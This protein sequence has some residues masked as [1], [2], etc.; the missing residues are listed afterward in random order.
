MQ[1]DEVYVKSCFDYKNGNIIGSAANNPICS[2]KTVMAY[3]VSSAFGNSKEIVSLVP[4][5]NINCNE[6]AHFTKEVCKLLVEC[7]FRVIVIITDNNRINRALFD[8]LS[9]GNGNNL[10]HMSDDFKT[11]LTFDSVHLLKSI[12]NN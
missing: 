4:V 6:F 12:R 3:L 8:I 10:Y 9:G 1:I 2:A 5:K 7:K 11:F